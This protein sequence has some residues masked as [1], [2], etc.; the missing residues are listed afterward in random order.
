M[1]TSGVVSNDFKGEVDIMLTFNK[2]RALNINSIAAGKEILDDNERFKVV[3]FNF[4]SGKGLPNHSHNGPASILVCDG[5]VDIEFV[6]GEKF[7]LTKGNFLGFD[8][9]I[10]HNVIADGLT[11]VIVTIGK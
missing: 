11:K 9:R 8:A 10:E 3:C 6:T 4:E 1:A 2:K 5:K 7:T